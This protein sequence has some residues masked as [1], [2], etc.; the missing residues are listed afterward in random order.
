[1]HMYLRQ[2]S[3]RGHRTQEAFGSIFNALLLSYPKSLKLIQ[4]VRNEIKSRTARR[5]AEQPIP[6]LYLKSLLELENLTYV[7]AALLNY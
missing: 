7:I 4:Y 5:I 6:L 1:M 2:F 3:G